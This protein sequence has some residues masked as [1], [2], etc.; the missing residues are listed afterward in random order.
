MRQF[1]RNESP[2]VGVRRLEHPCPEDN[3][4]AHGIGQ[5]V[6]ILRR[7]GGGVIGVHSDARKVVPEAL[8]HVAAQTV[9]QRRAGAGQDV[10]DR[11]RR[12]RR[13]LNPLATSGAMGSPADGMVG[14]LVRLPLE[15]VVTGAHRELALDQKRG[16]RTG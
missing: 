5:R 15:R 12:R 8:T 3:V 4:V 9:V 13:R 16:R 6:H 2:A 14:D 10:F 11:I 7:S 1:V